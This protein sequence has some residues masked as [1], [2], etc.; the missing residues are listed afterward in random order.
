MEEAEHNLKK[1]REVDLT[2]QTAAE[3][4]GW[5]YIVVKYTEKYLGLYTLTERIAEALGHVPG[6]VVA[7][8]K[9]KVKIP[10]PTKYNWPKGQKIP[11]RK[12]NGEP[13]K[14]KA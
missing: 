14:S 10:Q 3:E 11:G 9:E 8:K 6:G 5:A 12:F 2:K 1:R 4:A 7:P 13:I